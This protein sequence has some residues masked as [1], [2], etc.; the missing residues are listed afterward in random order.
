MTTWSAF[1]AQIMG[2]ALKD[3]DGLSWPDT[4]VHDALGWAHNT[5]CS[6]TALPKRVM[7][8]SGDLNPLT[9]VAYNFGVDSEFA[10]PSDLYEPLDMSGRV[11]VESAGSRYYFDPLT[12]TPNMKPESTKERWFWEVSPLMRLS[13]T[14]GIANVLHVHYFAYYPKPL[15]TDL[16]A[17]LL[18]PGWAEKAIAT[19]TAAYLLDGV[20]VESSMIDRWKEKNDSG[21]PEHNALR[22]QQQH[23]LMMYEAE[24]SKYPVQNRQN[25]YR[26]LPRWGQNYG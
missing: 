4:Q 6:H 1:R 5:F 9:G 26:V 13:Y 16:T 23:M 22:K 14:P 7:I 17:V 19:L 3:P 18:I 21:N 2:I 10:L 24:I 8:M 15:V 11:F 12:R 25:F 20:G